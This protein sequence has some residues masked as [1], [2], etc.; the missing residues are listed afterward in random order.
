MP[1]SEAA[2]RRLQLVAGARAARGGGAP[3]FLRIRRILLP[4][5][6]QTCATPCESRRL[7]PIA[8]GVRPFFASLQTW[9]MTSAGFCLNQDGGVR[10]YGRALFEMPFLRGKAEGA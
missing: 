7:T 5:T 10:R 6:W 9:S 2:A 4:V 1:G 8:E 3:F